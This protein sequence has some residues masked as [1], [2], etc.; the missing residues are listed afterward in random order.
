MFMG[1]CSSRVGERRVIEEAVPNGRAVCRRGPPAAYFKVQSLPL[2]YFGWFA[3]ILLAYCLL[4]TLM[5]RLNIPRF[6]WQ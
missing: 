6:G 5:K 4:T 1:Q 3:A 2:Q